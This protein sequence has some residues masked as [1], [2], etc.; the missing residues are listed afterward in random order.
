YF[1]VKNASTGSIIKNYEPDFGGL[2]YQQFRVGTYVDAED[3]VP[4]ANTLEV[5]PNPAKDMV[6]LQVELNGRKDTR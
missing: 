4:V 6:Y 5:F 3:F 1:R 2:I